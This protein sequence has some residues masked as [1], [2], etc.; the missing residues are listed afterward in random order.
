MRAL[1]E[2]LPRA[3][4]IGA[5]VALAATLPLA[6]FLWYAGVALANGAAQFAQPI[7]GEG[8]SIAVAIMAFGAYVGLLVVILGGLGASV[9]LV[10][11]FFRKR[12]SGGGA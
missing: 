10:A 4:R 9:G 7:V 11:V 5:V 2:A 1:W 3:G 12:F 6:P 8:A